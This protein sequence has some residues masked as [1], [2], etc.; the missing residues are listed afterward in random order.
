MLGSL[1]LVPRQVSVPAREGLRRQIAPLGDRRVL[2]TLATT[3]VTFTS[4]Y[5]L[6]TYMA[7]VFAPATD[8][9]GQRLAVLMFTLGVIATLG[10]Y[11]AGVLADR[12]GG[13]RVMRVAP[14]WVTAALVVLPLTTGSFGASVAFIVVFGVVAFSMSTPQQHRLITLDPKSASVLISLHASIL[15]LAIALSGVIGGI[16]ITWVGANRI[17]FIA[18]ALALLA[19]GLS[20]S[21]HRLT[22]RQAGRTDSVPRGA[23]AGGPLGPPADESA[24][25]EVQPMTQRD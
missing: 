14:V 21:A 9:S 12:I 2:A 8:G 22:Q 19:L 5:I 17:S 1:A 25:V 11:G 20:E 3:M 23:Q 18:A 16:G 4:V 13:R 15:Y 6:Y 24:A 7:E 10:N